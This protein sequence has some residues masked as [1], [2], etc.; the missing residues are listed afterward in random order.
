MLSI[1]DTSQTEISQQS[2]SQHQQMHGCSSSKIPS[3][4]FIVICTSSKGKLMPGTHA[5]TNFIITCNYVS[6]SY[7]DHRYNSK[8]NTYGNDLLL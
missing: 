1:P 3:N 8:F 6:N 5:H 4:L 7:Q 2:V